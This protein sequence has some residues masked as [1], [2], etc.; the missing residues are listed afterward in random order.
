MEGEKIKSHQKRFLKL[1]YFSPLEILTSLLFEETLGAFL[2]PSL[3]FYMLRLL[4]T[5][6]F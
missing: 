6:G 3:F 1:K 2:F 5:Q 4:R